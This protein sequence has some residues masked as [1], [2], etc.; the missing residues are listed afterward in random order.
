MCIAHFG[1]KLAAFITYLILNLMVGNLVLVYIIVLILSI[2]DF[3]V[4]KNITG[5]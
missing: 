3:W 4:V 1:F 2:L 5:R